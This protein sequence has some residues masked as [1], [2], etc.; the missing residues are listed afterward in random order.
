MKLYFCLI[1]LSSITFS[2]YIFKNNCILDFQ[3]ETWNEPGSDLIIF[4]IKSNEKSFRKNIENFEVVEVYFN[5]K[6]SFKSNL[7]LIKKIKNNTYEL[8]ISSPYFSI[9]YLKKEEIYK[10]FKQSDKLKIKL[11]SNKDILIF[12]KC[13]D[14]SN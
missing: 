6:K 12:S 9:D 11:K 10:L 7:F 5:E 2:N 13:I 3:F 1:L 4:N 8:K 14:T